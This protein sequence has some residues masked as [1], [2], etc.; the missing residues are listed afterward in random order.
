[1]VWVVVPAGPV[2]VVGRSFYG[3]GQYLM[4]RY[5]QPI[6]SQPNFFR[7]IF[8]GRMV[9]GWSIRMIDLDELVV[10]FLGIWSRPIL[11]ENIVGCE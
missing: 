9:I 6:S 7:D 1:M 2:P 5:D 10:L 8:E 4:G 11:F 3:I